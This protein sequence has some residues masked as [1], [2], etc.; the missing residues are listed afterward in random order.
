MICWLHH[1]IYHC[2]RKMRV[3]L[4]NCSWTKSRRKLLRMLPI[5]FLRSSFKSNLYDEPCFFVRKIGVEKGGNLFLIL[6]IL[7]FMT[8]EKY[9]HT[10]VRPFSVRL[11]SQCITD[12]YINMCVVVYHHLPSLSLCN[13]TFQTF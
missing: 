6:N 7:C 3:I 10:C 5:S 1:D 2:P 12:M 4:K 13:A 11:N 8:S 9:H